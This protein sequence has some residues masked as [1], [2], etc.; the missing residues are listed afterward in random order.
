MRFLIRVTLAVGVAAVTACSAQEWEIGGS[1]GY[2]MTLNR[3]VTRDNLSGKA[4]FRPG[5]AASFVGGTHLK[6]RLSGEIRYLYRD[7]DLKLSSGGTDVRFAGESHSVHYDMLVNLGGKTGGFRAF[8]VGGGGV[9]VYR[10]TGQERSTQPLSDLVAL[11]KTREVKPLI[12]IGAGVSQAI[13]GPLRLRIEVRDYITPFPKQVV[14]P[15]PAAKLTGWLHDFIPMV[16][17]SVVF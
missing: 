12:S 5:F 7:S 10:G 6:N 11:T 9:K 13:G 16:G 14:A 8:V 15:H 4:G 3:D 17:L 1:A 2:G